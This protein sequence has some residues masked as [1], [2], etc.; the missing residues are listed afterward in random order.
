MAARVTLCAADSA[1][2]AG[3][4]LLQD[5]RY[6][7]LLTTGHNKDGQPVLRMGRTQDGRHEVLREMVL[8][9]KESAEGAWILGCTCHNE[10]Y[11]FWYAPAAGD[12]EQEKTEE[13]VKEAMG[14]SKRIAVAEKLPASLLSS[15]VNGGFT[16]AYV[17]MYASGNGQV[18][19]G[20]ADFD[21][22]MYRGGRI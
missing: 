5:D 20:Y 22:F 10:T 1:A 7:Y 4:V 3:I 6:S 19:A 12:K 21:W 8:P 2:E 13:Q 15:N 9:Q 17:G 18:C 14:G 16:G 11:D